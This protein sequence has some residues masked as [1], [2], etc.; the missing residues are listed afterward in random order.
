MDEYHN[1]GIVAL[2]GM[3]GQLD[4]CAINARLDQYLATNSYGVVKEEGL[5][6]ARA[7]HGLHLVEPFFKELCE[8]TDLLDVV[9]AILCGAVYVHQ[10]KIN[11]KVAKFGEGWPWHQDYIFWKELDGIPRADLV[12]VAIY[13]SDAD[14]DSG[15]LTFLPGSQRWGNLCERVQSQGVASEAEWMSNVG[16]ELTFQVSAAELKA[17]SQELTPLTAI[18]A[19]GDIDFFH[20]QLVHGSGPNTSNHDRRLLIITYNRTDNLPEARKSFRPEFLCSQCFEPIRP[21]KKRTKT[22]EARA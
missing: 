3:L 16:R 13:L 6:A 12:N 1:A 9:E 20:P 19:A 18:R 2:S 15:P 21:Y 7:V 14:I 11:M 8:R 5:S 4:I 10:F 22:E 17:Q